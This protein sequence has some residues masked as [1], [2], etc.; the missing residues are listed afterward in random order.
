MADYDVAIAGYGPAGATAALLLG[1]LGHRVLVIDRLTAVYDRPRAFAMDHEILRVYQ[2]LGAIEAMLP[3]IAPFSASE[4]YGVDGQLIRRLTMVDPPYPLGWT[5]SVVFLQPPIEEALRVQVRAQKGVD[6]ALGCELLEFDEEAGD[7]EAGAVAVRYRAADGAARR[8]TA[9]Y[10]IGC[11]GASSTVRRQLGI[12]HDDLGFDEPWLVVDVLVN[13][14]DGA[15][16]PPTSA[17]FCEPARPTT[18][19]IGTGNHRRWEIMLLPGEDP[20]AMEQ[21]AQVWK[22]LSR[23][24]APEEGRLWRRA[25]YRFHALVASR[26]RA[27]RVFLAGDAA[28]QQ[29]PFLGQGM[30]QGVRDVANLGWKLDAVLRGRAGD[31]LLDTYGDERAAHVRRLTTT[32]KHIGETICERDP[33]RARRRDADLI[34]AAGGTVR[35]VPRQDL[36][37]PLECGLLSARAHPAN[38][39]LFPQPR[40]AHAGATAL[41][42]DVAGA[43]A[44]LMLRGDVDAAAVLGPA[45]AAGLG[46]VRF[47][48]P[49]GVRAAGV[50]DAAEQD[51]IAAA[52]FARH[53][54]AAALVRPDHYVYGVAATPTAIAALVGEFAA[55]VATCS[56]AGT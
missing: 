28:H 33:V 12:A 34:A 14:G 3:H 10:L 7:E 46:V 8:A 19:L 35:S 6:L 37:P 55:A 26:W 11:D 21:D 20:A 50:I 36:I 22:L 47:G 16:L 23:W 15:R 27:G 43:G 4:H 44:R 45:A 51:G 48:A 25:S 1:R 52:W 17:Q 29:P 38:G 24:I 18:Y 2:N 54:A 32:I 9:R 49:P 13:Q 30:C 39:T 31:A 56:P 40:I 5:P 53:E 41:L 42:D